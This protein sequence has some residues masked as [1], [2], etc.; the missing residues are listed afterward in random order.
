MTVR[1]RHSRRIITA[2]ADTGRRDDADTG[3]RRGPTRDTDK[4]KDN[5]QAERGRT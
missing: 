2:D 4:D 1:T 5:R 3:H